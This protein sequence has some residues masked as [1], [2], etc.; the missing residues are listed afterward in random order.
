MSASSL[1]YIEDRL[2][3]DMMLRLFFNEKLGTD[4]IAQ[5]LVCSEAEVY[6]TLAHIKPRG[7]FK[8]WNGEW[9]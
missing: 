3:Q 5:R 7:R 2:E 8:K 9:A 1:K 4:K 6:N